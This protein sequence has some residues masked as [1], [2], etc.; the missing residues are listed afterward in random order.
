MVIFFTMPTIVSA[1]YL[2]MA[3]V[4]FGVGATFPV[5]LNFI[6]GAF[7]NQSGT[8]F[9]VA[10]FI[11][12]LGQYT[13]N[14]LVGDSFAAGNYLLFPCM[15]IGAIVMIMILVPVAKRISSRMK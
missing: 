3:L 11:A 2:G 13:F 12:L 7:R 8:A 4:G 6:G 15:L 14:K 10:I 1:V 9:S 5:V